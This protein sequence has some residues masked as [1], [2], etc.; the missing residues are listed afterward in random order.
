MN[1]N[2]LH[3]VTSWLNDLND[4]TAG[5]TPLADAK[6]KIAAIALMLAEEYPAGAFT[7]QSLVLVATAHNW[8]P[9]YAQ[10]VA[11]LSP[12]WKERRPMPKLL[13]APSSRAQQ[14]RD[15]EER[16]DSWRNITDAEI[17][18]KI[19]ALRDHPM[20][21]QLGRLLAIAIS[22]HAPDKLHQLPPG[23][24]AGIEPRAA[25]DP[26]TPEQRGAP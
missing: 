2:H 13:A 12:W 3:T 17:R 16:A 23:F 14:E 18:A 22:R 21:Q 11:V 26:G 1:R 8:F 9:S 24:I 15:E 5:Q 4:L 10:I 19:W 6:R 25:N 7:R 20:R